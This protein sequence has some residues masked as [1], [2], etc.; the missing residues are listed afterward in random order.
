MLFHDSSENSG[1]LVCKYLEFD[2]DLVM[3]KRKDTVKFPPLTVHR[4]AKQGIT[5]SQKRNEWKAVER[6]FIF[7]LN[8]ITISFKRE[9]KKER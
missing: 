6:G 3:I 1:S 8:F 7:I 2:I 9:K 5:L 4:A